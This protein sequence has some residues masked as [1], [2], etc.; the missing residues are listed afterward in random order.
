MHCAAGFLAVCTPVLVRMAKLGIALRFRM[1]SWMA[2]GS[3]RPSPGRTVCTC[4]S[5]S[6]ALKRIRG[7]M[8]AHGRLSQK[9][10]AHHFL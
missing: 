10:A 9:A 8:L 5:S 6:G 4:V 2:P 7:R 3:M 1:V